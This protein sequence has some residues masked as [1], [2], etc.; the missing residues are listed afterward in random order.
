MS[1]GPLSPAGVTTRIFV[2]RGAPISVEGGSLRETLGRMLVRSGA[3]S[4][5]DYERVIQRMTERVI[6]SEHQRMGEVLVQLHLMDGADVFQALSRQATEKIVESFSAPRVE[7]M[8]R[9]MDA[10]PVS[11]E[12]LE[13]PS[14]AALLVEGVKRHVSGDERNALHTPLAGARV[15]MS[16]TAAELRLTGEDARLAASLNGTRTVAEI[17][18][19][20]ERAH[21]T[22]AALAL[23]DALTV[24]TPVA[25][26]K[27][28]PAPAP[29]ASVRFARDV[30]AS[31]KKSESAAASDA[32]TQVRFA[33]EDAPAT[34]AKQS[35]ESKAR[36]EAEQLFQSARKLVEREK[37]QDA[38]AALLRAVALQPNEPEYRMY[39]AWAAYLAARVAQRIARAKAVACARKMSGADPR[40]GKPHAI[41]GRLLLDDGDAKGATH[42]FEFALLRDPG[43][44]D[45][46]KGLAQTRGSKPAQK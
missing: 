45:A 44:E 30:V 18:R 28:G 26:L 40:A 2:R 4:E 24:A 33:Y 13:V 42:E 39:E 36:L 15:R 41:L 5:R 3:L 8:F 22:L 23:V 37:F 17:C 46:K 11:I 16:G 25:K 7:L 14:F 32:S 9:E 29:R 31:P 1:T 27:I 10:L 21:A 38:S 12:P 20:N 19:T 6:D 43:D 35:N 34:G